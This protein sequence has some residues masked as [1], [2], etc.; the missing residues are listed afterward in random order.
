MAIDI[1]TGTGK[2]DMEVI[3]VPFGMAD[4]RIVA[5]FAVGILDHVAQLCF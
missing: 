3:G 4:N 2:P 5:L 1:R